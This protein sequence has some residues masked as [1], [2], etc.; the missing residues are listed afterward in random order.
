MTLYLLA[1]LIFAAVLSEMSKCSLFYQ[2]STNLTKWDVWWRAGPDT[3]PQ[4]LQFFL[5]TVFMRGHLEKQGRADYIGSRL[6]PFSS[7]LHELD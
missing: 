5:H 6:N 1:F 2:T 7:D 3:H 4:K